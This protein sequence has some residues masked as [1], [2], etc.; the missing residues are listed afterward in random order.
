MDAAR[1]NGCAICGGD[2]KRFHMD[3]DHKTKKVRGVLCQ[4]CNIALGGFR[5]NR[6][7]LTA[8]IDY[9]SGSFIP[10]IS[11]GLLF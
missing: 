9:L 1:K 8:A 7:S 6:T 10:G 4:G 3:H 5:D 2:S 11:A